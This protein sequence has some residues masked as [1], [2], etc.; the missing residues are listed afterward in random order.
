M[1]CR[2]LLVPW[3]SSISCSRRTS[4]VAG[5]PVSRSAR[6]FSVSEEWLLQLAAQDRNAV[7]DE[8]V[9]QFGT[10]DNDFQ[11]TLTSI[12]VKLV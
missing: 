3:S 9:E 7:Q 8:C 12:H 10:V 5:R 1:C 2:A 6:S 11:N 4:S